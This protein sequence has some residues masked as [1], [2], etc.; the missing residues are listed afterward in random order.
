SE[1]DEHLFCLW[2]L[3][4]IAAVIERGDEEIKE[5]S[6]H[7]GCNEI[8]G[9]YWGNSICSAIS[10]VFRVF[11]VTQKEPYSTESVRQPSAFCKIEIPFGDYLIDSHRYFLCQDKE[12]RFFVHS[13]VDLGGRLADSFGHFLQLYLSEPEKL[14]L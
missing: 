12:D 13:Q 11:C 2:P 4:Q 8:R 5:N 7:M 10:R 1:S 9:G 14:Y 6:E 3:E